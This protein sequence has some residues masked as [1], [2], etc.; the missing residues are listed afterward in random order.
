M[1]KI[2]VD[3]SLRSLLANFTTRIELCDE[4]GRTVGFFVPAAEEQQRQYAWARHQFTDAEIDA[5]RRE[6]GGFTIEQILAD[7]HE[8]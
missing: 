8:E 6:S 3:D 5:A 1:L 4:S 7:L 2:T